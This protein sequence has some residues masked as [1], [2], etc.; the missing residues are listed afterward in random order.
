M[1]YTFV[2]I[3]MVEI[4]G[5]MVGSLSFQLQGDRQIPA[6]IRIPERIVQPVGIG[7]LR[8]R[9][10]EQPRER[11]HLRE[12]ARGGVV[13]ARAQ[14]LRAGIVARLARLSIRRYS[15]RART[16]CWVAAAARRRGRRTTGRYPRRPPRAII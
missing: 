1:F 7:L 16:G 15:R 6:G 8:P 5:V 4:A 2:Q 11:I 14:N 10:R 3:L 13:P 12:A 9:Q